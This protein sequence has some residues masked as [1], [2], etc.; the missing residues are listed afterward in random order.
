[1]YVLIASL[2]HIQQRHL[3]LNRKVIRMKEQK[4]KKVNSCALSLKAYLEF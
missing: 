1:M 2:S 3:S 4:T